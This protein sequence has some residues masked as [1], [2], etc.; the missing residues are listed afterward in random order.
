MQISQFTL[1]NGLRVIH[2]H[3]ANSQ[4]VAVNVL[5]NV[6]SK[7][8]SP[9]LTGLAHLFEHLMFGGSANVPDFDKQ[10]ER[11]GGKN[12][13]W[14]SADFTNF[15]EFVPKQ[16]IETALWLESDRMKALAFTPKSLEVQRKVVIEEFK[17]TQQ[18]TPYGDVFAQILT[19]IYKTHPYQSPVIGKD[20]SHIERVTMDDV[21]EFFYSHYLPNNAV[22]SIV[23][24]VST[25][26]V[27]RLVTK[28]FSD[29]PSGTIRNREIAPEPKQTKPRFISC[30]RENAP[31]NM[32]MRAYPCCGNLDKQSY[33][34]RVMCDALSLG[35]SSRLTQNVMM[36]QRGLVS[37]D[38]D[39]MDF[40]D[41]SFVNLQ[42][43]LKPETSFEDA[44][45]ILDEVIE[46]IKTQPITQ[47]EITKSVNQRVTMVYRKLNSRTNYA[48]TL[49]KSVL[50]N[51]PID[52]NEMA[53][54]F[55]KVTTEDVKK[56]VS[57][58]FRSECCTT[59]H[60]GPNAQ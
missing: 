1:D 5:Y 50:E 47:S 25:D 13:A 28:W 51:L 30:H 27:K 32:I 53:D 9:E 56:Q 33:S 58:I 16:N 4:F 18:N 24:D 46:N 10:M 15:Y 8:E 40:N 59:L 36:K 55:R 14:T 19:V 7:H 57:D 2:C 39:I 20:I 44:E 43:M 23:G 26:E 35:E 3:D 29:I 54:R 49:A 6:G 17:Q 34:I 38:C 48:T 45:K 37:I 22:L 60:Y 52:I 42:C 41:T 31:H 21:K 11:A 12:N